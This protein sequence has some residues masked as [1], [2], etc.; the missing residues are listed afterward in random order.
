MRT[1]RPDLSV[2]GPPV[3]TWAIRMRTWLL[4]DVR[5]SPE[6]GSRWSARSAARTTDLDAGEDWRTLAPAVGAPG[7]SP[8]RPPPARG[9]VRKE[10]RR[11]DAQTYLGARSVLRS[12]DGRW[13]RPHEGC[14]RSFFGGCPEQARGSTR[15]LGAGRRSSRRWAGARCPPLLPPPTPRR[16]GPA[17]CGGTRE[18]ACGRRTG[19]P[20]G[21][22]GGRAPARSRRGRVRPS[23]RRSG[24][25]RRA[26]SAAPTIPAERGG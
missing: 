6:P 23:W 1:S 20:A 25:H 26:T 13:G 4:V 15:V 11:V 12:H 17:G 3:N 21:G 18:P 19:R 9:G 2:G 16:P 24:P 10:T 14:G 22:P 5:A 8:S 7:V